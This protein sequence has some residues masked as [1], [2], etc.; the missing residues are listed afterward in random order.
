MEGH[1]YLVTEPISEPPTFLFGLNVVYTSTLVYAHAVLEV[2]FRNRLFIS[3]KS[4]FPL[5]SVW[6]GIIVC[7]LKLF[8][9]ESSNF[10]KFDRI[11]TF[12]FL[13]SHMFN[14]ARSGPVRAVT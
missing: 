3:V 2:V 1:F 7:H 13:P 11:R 4:F 5:S 8:F 6:T 12:K 14:S 10:S 9:C